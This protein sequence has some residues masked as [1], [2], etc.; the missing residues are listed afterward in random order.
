MRG[1]TEPGLHRIAAALL[2]AGL[3]V[4][5]LASAAAAQDEQVSR[6]AAGWDAAASAADERIGDPATTTSELDALR[7]GLVQ[8]RGEAVEAEKAAQPAID[9]LQKRLDALGPPPPEGTTEPEDIAGLRRDLR[10]QLAVARGPQLEAQEA[11]SRADSLIGEIDRIVRGRFSAE[12]MSRGPSPLN[13]ATWVIAAQELGARFYDYG[14]AFAGE[15]REA[16]SRDRLLQRLPLNLL[17]VVSGLLIAFSLRKWITGRVERRLAAPIGRSEAAWLLALR[18]ITRLIVPALG[19]GLFFAAFDSRGLPVRG[20]DGRIFSLPP[21]VIVLIFSGWLSGS[22]FAPRFGAFRPV[23]LDDSQ[24]RRAARLTMMLG[25][26]LTFAALLWSAT[27]HW[28]LSTTTQA[29]LT[30]PLVVVACI[31]LWQAA[32]LIEARH[33]MVGAP[34]TVTQ[35]A[36]RLLS[37]FLRVVAVV[38]PVLAVFGWLPGAAFLSLRTSLALGLTGA[39]I[40]VYDLA[41]RAIR[42]LLGYPRQP[43]VEEGLFPV[44]VAGIVMLAALPVFAIIW[45]ARP[46]D[47]A[48]VWTLLREGI[49]IGGV[50]ISASVVL[51]LIVVFGLGAALTRLAQTL[52]RATVLPRTRLDTGGRNAVLAGIGYVGFALAGLAAIAAAGLDLSSLAIVAGALSVGIGF[53][54]QNV[55]SNFVSGIILLVERPVKEG[56]WIEVGGYSG[57]VKGINVRSTEIE[58]FDKASVIL[59]NSDLV[60]GTVLNRTHQGVSGRLQVPVGVAYDSDPRQ[61]EA[62]L[63]GIA[64]EHPLVLEEPAPTV[65]FMGFGASS[66]DFEIRCW[67]RDV[68]FML[69][70]HSDMNFEIV[71]RFRAA[72]IVIPFP[73]QDVHLKGAEALAAALRDRNSEG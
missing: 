6:P 46:S 11:Y 42:L 41:T 3:T 20:G 71:A 35:G 7:E 40:V 58:L 44:V 21:F 5:L 31:A 33:R 15:I 67:L 51:T 60:A 39:C 62:V 55:V 26:A 66:M 54:L 27:R 37:R 48:D 53:G 23:P 50:R 32:A 28:N 2:A 9:E 45:G 1:R 49:A 72:G 34:E 52:M 18:N 17:L 73:Q 47:I 16:A 10:D 14:A 24:A 59:P 4:W 69:T 36:L 56:D 61:V 57:Y 22:L 12:L 8:L 68:N 70:A 19:A 38:A 29:A 63:L 64:E 13:L 43:G 25:T 65:I 30:F